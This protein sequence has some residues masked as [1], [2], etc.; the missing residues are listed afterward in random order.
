MTPHP[1]GRA[2]TSTSGAPSAPPVQ[3][4]RFHPR[5]PA[6]F[7]GEGW[8]KDAHWAYLFHISV[9]IDVTAEEAEALTTP[10]TRHMEWNRCRWYFVKEDDPLRYSVLLNDFYEEVHG[11]RLEHL[12]YYTELIKPHGWCHK[13]ILERKQLNCCKHLTG[14]EPPPDDVE[15]PSESSLCSHRTAYEAAK[16]GGTGKAFKRARSTLLETLVIHGLED[17]YYYILG[18]EKGPPPKNSETVPMEV[19][20]EAGAAASQGGED[21]PPGHRQVSWEEQVQAEEERMST[22]DPQRKLPLPP[23]LDTTST[24]TPPV[25]PFTSDDGF[26]PVWGRKS[27]DKR[28]RDPSKDPTP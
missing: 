17:E 26:T 13:V 4:G 6:D 19:C 20:S 22:E 16:W 21:A 24:A 5:H 2:F 28:P 15:R 18:R 10:V 8:K 14:V 7:R 25:A 11:Y 3:L 1:G 12:D 9:T 23:L 27:R